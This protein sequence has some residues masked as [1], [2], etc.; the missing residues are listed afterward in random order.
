MV[1]TIIMFLVQLSDV[2][3]I[4]RDQTFI[5]FLLRGL[6][7]LA[8]SSNCSVRS[9]DV[10]TDYGRL[11][12]LPPLAS[13]QVGQARTRS[14]VLLL[15]SPLAVHRSEGRGRPDEV[16]LYRRLCFKHKIACTKYVRKQ[17]RSPAQEGARSLRS[18]SYA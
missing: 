13:E 17:T 8:D 14:M 5:N 18:R 10:Y 4:A 6:G 16:N 3:R 11:Y 15:W 7:R 2:S 1:D 9:S 12:T